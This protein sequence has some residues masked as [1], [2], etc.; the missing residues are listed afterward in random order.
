MEALAQSLNPASRRYPV[1]AEI[2]GDGIAFRVWA[3]A[4]GRVAVILEPAGEHVLA[5]EGNGYF[6]GLVP[7][8][9]AGTRYRFRLDDDELLYP[10]PVSRRQP[11]GPHGP[12]EVV[13]AGRFEWRDHGWRGATRHGQVIYEMHIGTFTKEGT[14]A[15]AAEHLEKLRDL[16]VTMIEMMPVND[17][18]GRFGWGYDGV[19]LY[20]P[21]RLYGEPDDLRRFVDAAHAIGLAVILDVVYNHIGPDGNFLERFSADY[22][23]DRHKNEWGKAINFDGSNNAGSREFFIT[24]AAYWV[25]EFHFDGLRLDATQ[26]LF[27]GSQDHVV[28][29][30]TRAARSAAGDRSIFMV[31]ENEPQHTILVRSP[32]SGGYGVDALWNDDF[33]HSAMVALTGR[34]EAYYHD[35]AGRAQ[36]FLSALKYGCLFQ[37]QTYAW[38]NAPRGSPGLDL[39]PSHTVVFTQNHDQVA[40]SARGRRL[41][42]LTSPASVRAMTALMLLAP[43]TPMLFQG[44]EFGASAPFLFFADYQ[45]ELGAGVR[46]GRREFLSQFQSIADPGV[47]DHLADPCSEKTFARCKLDW[48]EFERNGAAVALHRD[49]LR[50]RRDDP[51]LSRARDQSGSRAGLDGAVFGDHCLLVRFFGSESREDRLLFVNFGGSLF[52]RSLTEPLAAA[53]ENC[54]WAVVWSSEDALYG[55]DG[56]PPI[57]GTNGWHIPGQ[58]AFLL[59]PRPGVGP[60]AHIR[61]LDKEKG[62]AK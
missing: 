30:L 27:D 31:A 38:Q 42:Q 14:W 15:A 62:E 16:G 50:L 53:P 33:H 58:A 48:T 57:E 19:G 22:F 28:A 32:E 2:S 1:G 37:G 29:A 13:D 4:R 41:H 59:S 46:K 10:D 8:R 12:S 52:P 44:Q 54:H 45:G 47:A 9:G 11:E 18:P 7:G 43:Q 17:F 20:A 35:Y 21:T 24:N 40:N 26:A 61:L 51:T 56:T 55:G 23:T 39:A 34:A 25:D 3:P 6:S 60:V 5:N 36:E 49:L